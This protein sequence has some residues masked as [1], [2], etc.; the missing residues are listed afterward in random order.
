MS[1]HWPYRREAKVGGVVDI[2][3]ICLPC[4]PDAIERPAWRSTCTLAA[5]RSTAD[6]TRLVHARS[7]TA[8]HARHV[9]SQLWRVCKC[10]LC[11]GCAARSGSTFRIFQ[12][13]VL[14]R[15]MTCFATLPQFGLHPVSS[16]D[17]RQTLWTF[18]WIPWPRGYDTTAGVA[19]STVPVTWGHMYVC[20]ARGSGRKECVGTFLKP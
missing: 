2:P 15:V 14:P 5:Q 10:R 1:G 9:C 6:A 13:N 18:V 3:A 8:R 11:S 16:D 20:T 19:F 7:H 4:C 17:L 12:M